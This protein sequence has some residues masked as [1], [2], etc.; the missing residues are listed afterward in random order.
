MKR[1][2]TKRE[3]NQ[4]TADVLARVKAGK[5]MIVT[6]R[7]VPR[8]RIEVVEADADPVAWLRAEGRITPASEDPP[9]WPDEPADPR[10]S[11]ARIKALL[12]EIRG[13]R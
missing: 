2:V 1:T 10:Y 4:Q 11:P 7:G 6:E 9:A 3:L 8:W 12:D 13:D 5:P